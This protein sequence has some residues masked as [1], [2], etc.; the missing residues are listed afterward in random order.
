LLGMKAVALRNSK[1]EKQVYV[2][3]TAHA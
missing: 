1:K 2:E 3:Q